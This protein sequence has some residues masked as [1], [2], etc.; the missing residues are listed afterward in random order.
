MKIKIID[1]ILIISVLAVFLWNVYM[2]GSLLMGK[3]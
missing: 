1:K 3:F 2:I